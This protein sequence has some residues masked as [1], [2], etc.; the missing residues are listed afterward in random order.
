M[1]TY[2]VTARAVRLRRHVAPLDKML[3]TCAPERI[4]ESWQ[5]LRPLLA[6]AF[7]HV[8]TAALMER[9]DYYVSNQRLRPHR[10]RLL[11][12]RYGWRG[13]AYGSSCRVYVGKLHEEP[14]SVTYT[15]YK[16]MPEFSVKDWREHLIALVAHE[17]YHRWSVKPNGKRQEFDCEL[18][19]FDAV[20]RWRRQ[21]NKPVVSDETDCTG[22]GE[23]GM[24]EDLLVP[25]EAC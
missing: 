8:K 5:V 9:G 11:H 19:A 10:L 18:V 13:R 23:P 22:L 16:D 14:R 15:R 12:T 17:L 20:E 21:Q 6:A 25:S 7:Y 1:K 4:G 3:V 24:P 2:T